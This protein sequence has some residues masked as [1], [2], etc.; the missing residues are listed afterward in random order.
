MALTP[1]V[2]VARLA[3]HGYAAPAPLTDALDRYARLRADAPPIVNADAV[4][5]AWLSGGSVAAREAAIAVA[6]GSE[7]RRTHGAAVATVEADARRALLA[8]AEAVCRCLTESAAPYVER[9]T[10]AVKLGS[11]PAVLLREGRTADAEAVA[12]ADT[13]ALAYLEIRSL[14]REV[15]PREIRESVFS[16]SPDAEASRDVPAGGPALVLGVLRNG[17]RLHMPTPAEVVELED[18]AAARAKADAD[19]RR[20]AAERAQREA[21]DEAR[22]K[23]AMFRAMA[24]ERAERFAAQRVAQRAELAELIDAGLSRRAE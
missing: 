12:R 8:D 24:R 7:L 21:N 14:W 22:E 5:A 23:A 2:L 19:E 3:E 13:D 16:F 1:D 20:Q 11:D 6:V 10:R 15:V 18:E 4:T 17:G 9:M